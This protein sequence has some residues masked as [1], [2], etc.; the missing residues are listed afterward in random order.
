MKRNPTSTHRLV[1]KK[2]RKPI[3]DPG[4]K[5]LPSYVAECAACGWKMSG[6]RSRR[7]AEAQRKAHR[8][9]STT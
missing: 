7:Q 2:E 4:G 1:D 8:C 5:A 3:K 6:L 9:D